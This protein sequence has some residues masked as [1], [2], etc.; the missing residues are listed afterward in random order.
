MVVVLVHLKELIHTFYFLLFLETCIGVVFLLEC[1]ELDEERT[2]ALF[3]GFVP[4]FFKV[5]IVPL[6][7]SVT[8]EINN[9][10]SVVENPV[11]SL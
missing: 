6:S 1:H 3:G 9:F 2:L 7:L 5:N 8:V 11:P 4:L 10:T